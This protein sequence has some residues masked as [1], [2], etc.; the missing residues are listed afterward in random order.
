MILRKLLGI[1]AVSFPLY[2]CE[3]V[4][5]PEPPKPATMELKVVGENYQKNLGIDAHSQY[6]FSAE[7]N[8]QLRSFQCEHSRKAQVLDSLVDKG[9]TVTLSLKSRRRWSGRI[10][11]EKQPITFY[12]DE[13]VAVN[14][15]K[16]E[17]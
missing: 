1:T 9:D 12:Y 7:V 14:G 10:N 8:G 17:W 6:T 15:I 13:L 2:G 16:I 11:F 3:P 4:V 5:R